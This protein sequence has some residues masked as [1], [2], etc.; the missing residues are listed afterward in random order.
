MITELAGIQVEILEKEEQP[1][2]PGKVSP[3]SFRLRVLYTALPFLKEPFMFSSHNP[4]NPRDQDDIP[5]GQQP[6]WKL[7]VWPDRIEIQGGY[8]DAGP[9][10]CWDLIMQ[11]HRNLAFIRIHPDC[12]EMSVLTYPVDHLLL[13]FAGLWQQSIILHASCVVM[14]D[15]AILICGASGAGK[16][17]TAL[18]FRQQGAKVMHDDKVRLCF[19][20]SHCLAYPMPGGL[21]GETA[22]AEVGT[23]VILDQKGS[24]KLSTL[25]REEG[26]EKLIGHM[27]YIPATTDLIARQMSILGSISELVDFYKIS[28]PFEPSVAATLIPVFFTA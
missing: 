7:N 23:V 17:T 16:S 10:D 28:L 25:N 18:W 15:K 27:Q 11:P 14:Q 2:V 26:F 19:A 9:E 21:Q 6:R 8:P 5:P 20:G 24:L 12:K 4:D 3:P 22:M 13:Y 1:Q